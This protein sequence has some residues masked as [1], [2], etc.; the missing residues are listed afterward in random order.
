MDT[1]LTWILIALFLFIAFGRL[2]GTI[3]GLLGDLFRWLGLG[4]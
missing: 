1:V 4:K 2:F 3:F